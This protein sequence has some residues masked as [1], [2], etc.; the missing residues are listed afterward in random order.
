MTRFGN[1][2]AVLTGAA[3]FALCLAAPG[4][5]RAQTLRPEVGKPLQRAEALMRAGNYAGANAAVAEAAR[6]RGLTAEESFTIQELRGSIAQSSKNLPVASKI[7]ADMLASG[8]VPPAE[9]TKLY[10]AEA[11]MAYQLKNYPAVISWSQKYTASGGRDPAVRALIIQAYYLNRDFANAA[12]LQKAQIDA[13]VAAR[14]KP[15]EQQLQLL[16]RCQQE[17]GDKLG[18][19]N[20]MGLLVT[21]YP[22]PDYWQNL[23]HAAQTRP[24]YNSRLDIDIDRFELATGLVTKP[25]DLMDMV[26]LLLQ[27]PNPGEAKVVV[28]QAFASGVLGTGPE[29]PRQQR[30]RDLVNKNYATELKALPSREA[31][32]QSSHDG[33]LAASLG[34]EYVGFGQFDKGIALMQTGLKKGGLRHPDD[35]KLHLGLAY[36]K[37]GKKAAAVQVLRGVGGK[38]GQAEIARLWILQISK[39]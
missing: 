1:R 21:Y 4:A 6:A 22:K 34:D 15:S 17:M 37:A 12:K 35:T 3:A 19:G 33:N 9:Q 36:M 14:Q 28:D 27:V 7:F 20:T 39:A 13:E 31:D 10:L 38:E 2:A 32:A 23:I 5:S 16:A 8:R 24:G 25:A 18:F 30:L 11:S 26:E 29:A